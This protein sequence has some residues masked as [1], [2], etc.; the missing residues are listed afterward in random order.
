V[1]VRARIRGLMPKTSYQQS[2]GAR[3][4]SQSRDAAGRTAAGP[5]ASTG[6]RGGGGPASGV[7]NYNGA[8]PQRPGGATKY[9][10]G[11]GAQG[12]RSGGAGGPPYASD[13]GGAGASQ[14]GG[15]RGGGNDGRYAEGSMVRQG[16]RGGGRGDPSKSAPAP[17]GQSLRY[18]PPVSQ[19]QSGTRANPTETW[20][21][22]AWILAFQRDSSRQYQKL[23]RENVAKHNYEAV[24]YYQAEKRK[25]WHAAR[26]HS[27]RLVGID[28]KA[29]EKWKLPSLP[30]ITFAKQ[31]TAD[32]A[33]MLIRPGNNP[34]PPSVVAM[35]FAN[36]QDVGGGY[37]TGAKAQEEDLCRQFPMLY[38]S[39]TKAKRDGLYPFGPPAAVHPVTR[40]VQDRRKYTEVLFTEDL[41]MYR[42]GEEDGY[43]IFPSNERLCLSFV[44]AAAPNIPQSEPFNEDGLLATLHHTF[45]FPQQVLLTD[46]KKGGKRYETIV[47]GAWGCGAFGNDPYDM[48]CIFA[49]A[50][51][52]HGCLYKRVHFAIPASDRDQSNYESFRKAFVEQFQGTGIAI[53]EVDQQDRPAKR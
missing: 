37:L 33:H 44:A 7:N 16:S 38:S 49:K 8:A 27:S 22:R 28:P 24:R 34:Y 35:N 17:R 45:I 40:K 42:K 2:S 32:A 1:T 19:S 39:L 21:A 13:Y 30:R 36:G 51:K 15:P 6:G 50:V 48:A 10:Q 18:E 4:R 12:P 20:D 5:A 46:P 3:D 14:R 53:E 9:Y 11:H 23:C 52:S 43:G 29:L 31:T 25:W 26:S 41:V 47:C